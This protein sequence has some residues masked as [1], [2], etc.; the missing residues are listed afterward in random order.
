M[1]TTCKN[2]TKHI[3]ILDLLMKNWKLRVWCSLFYFFHVICKI[4]NFNMW[5]PKHLAQASCTELTLKVKIKAYCPNIYTVP[6]LISQS[7]LSCLWKNSPL[8]FA[9]NGCK[10]HC[11]CHL[12]NP[13]KERKY[14]VFMLNI[15]AKVQIWSLMKNGPSLI[16]HDVFIHSLGVHF[17]LFLKSDG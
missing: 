12:E 7:S 4:S 3:K 6:V 11:E 17:N 5:T 15:Q 10:F 14:F 16:S 2:R 1:Q 13:E 8:R 9:S